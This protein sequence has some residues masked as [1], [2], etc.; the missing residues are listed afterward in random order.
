MKVTKLHPGPYDVLVQF[1]ED[2]EEVHVKV[3]SEVMQSLKDDGIEISEEDL[4]KLL[5]SPAALRRAAVI[6]E[7]GEEVC[8]PMNATM[9]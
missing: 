2:G 1:S 8:R 3:G 7:E 9:N 4:I 6:D 5:L